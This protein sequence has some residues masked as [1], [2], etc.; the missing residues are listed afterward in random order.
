MPP[1]PKKKKT[2]RLVW[3]K[4]TKEISS[5]PQKSKPHPQVPHHYKNPRYTTAVN[6]IIKF[7]FTQM[8]FY[9]CT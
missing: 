6:T 3:T 1:P 2:S 5:P 9:K 4:W 7:I 8:S